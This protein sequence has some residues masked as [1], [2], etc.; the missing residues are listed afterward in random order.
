MTMKNRNRKRLVWAAAI[1]AAL[2]LSGCSSSA[3][4][5]QSYNKY[6]SKDGTFQIQ[7][8]AGW[9]A[10]GGGKAGYAWAKF[11][12]GSA[13]IAVNTNVVGSLVGDI[14]GGGM[15]GASRPEDM[16]HE[17]DPVAVVHEMEREQF[18]EDEGVKEQDP[19]EVETGM[20]GAKKAE[21]TG[22]KTFGGEI[23]GYRVTALGR[24]YRFRVVCRC[25]KDQWQALQPVFDKVI[26]TL[27]VGVP[28]F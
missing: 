10:E 20:R 27:R 19:V 17:R 18:E 8:P 2:V 23:H 6:N 25:D 1:G 9:Q 15:M 3:V 11:T 26:P 22:T 16:G 4:V 12:S 7:Y 13:E 24:D 14:A 28:E 21:F 5:P